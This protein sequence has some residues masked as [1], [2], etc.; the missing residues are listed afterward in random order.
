MTGGSC[1]ASGQRHPRVAP[2]RER[3]LAGAR[4]ALRALEDVEKVLTGMGLHG[5]LH[6]VASLWVASLCVLGIT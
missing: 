3:W 1:A 4:R 2:A 5:G 6:G